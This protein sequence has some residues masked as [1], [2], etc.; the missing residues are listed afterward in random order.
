MSKSVSTGPSG[1]LFWNQIQYSEIKITTPFETS[2]EIKIVLILN[3]FNWIKMLRKTKKFVGS[4][5]KRKRGLKS[6]NLFYLSFALT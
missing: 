5:V 6:T 3:C 2:S 4:E 1:N